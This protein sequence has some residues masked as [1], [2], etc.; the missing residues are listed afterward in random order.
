MKK[1]IA[2]VVFVGGGLY[3][4]PAETVSI[5]FLIG[6]VMLYV[7]SMSSKQVEETDK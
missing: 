6:V 7:I 5:L 1:R 2:G 3:F 4:F